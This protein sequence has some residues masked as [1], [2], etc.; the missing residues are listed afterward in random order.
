MKG[1]R[2][3]FFHT[4]EYKYVY[5]N[6]FINV[7]NIEEVTSKFTNGYKCFKPEFYGLNEEI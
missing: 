6:K 2:D 3:N 7:S 5:D 1:C 4:F